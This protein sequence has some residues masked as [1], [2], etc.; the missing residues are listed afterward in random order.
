MA[1]LKNPTRFFD[2]GSRVLGLNAEMHET[3]QSSTATTLP[4]THPAEASET[5]ESVSPKKMTPPQK[6]T[7]YLDIE[8]LPSSADIY[9]DGKKLNE[10]SPIRRYP[11]PANKS[12][13]VSAINTFSNTRADAVISVKQD[14][15]KFIRLTPKKR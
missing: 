10:K 11:V 8:T 14:A 12:I 13:T 15:I 3:K 7:G 5:A 2:W 9:I 1:F 4:E 6:A